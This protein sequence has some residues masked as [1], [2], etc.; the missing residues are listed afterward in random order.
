MKAMMFAFLAIAVIAVAANFGLSELGFS[1]ADE[2]TSAAVRL[3]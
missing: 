1:T 2:N 3:D